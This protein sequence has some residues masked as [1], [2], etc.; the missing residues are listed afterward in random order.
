MKKLSTILLSLLLLICSSISYAQELTLQRE[1]KNAISK[2]TRTLSGDPGKNYWIN[3][4]DYSLDINVVF[5]GDTTWIVGSG[6]IVY[7]NN[8]P[9]DLN[10][11][12]L[13]SYPDI[14]APA[15]IRN[16]YFGGAEELDLVSYSDIYVNGDTIPPQVMYQVRTSTNIVLRLSEPIAAGDQAV[17]DIKWRYRMHPQINIRQGV[18][19]SKSL[20]IAYF[21]PQVAVYDDIYGW[22]LVDYM[23]SV[24]FYNDFNNYDVRI[25]LP[26][27]YIVWGGGTLQNPEKV[28]PKNILEGYQKALK[29]DNIVSIIN[30]DDLPLEKEIEG[31]KTWHFKSEKSPDFTFAASFTHKWDASSLEVEPGR[32]VLIS[33]VYPTN[34]AH[35]GSA[36]RWS[37]ESIEYLSFTCPGVAYPWPFMTVFNSAEGSGGME[38]PMMVNNGEQTTE[39]G[40]RDVIFHEIAHSYV[41]FLTGANERRWSWLDEG[42]ATY[43][44]LKWTYEIDHSGESDFLRIYRNISGTAS[45]IPLMVPSYQIMDPTASTNYSYGRSSQAFMV[46]ESQLGTEKM[47][48]LWKTFTTTWREKHPSPWDYFALVNRIAG[49]DMNWLLHPWYYEFKSADL[50]LAAVDTRRGE[51]TVK[52]I[53][54]LPL[55]VY[56]TLTYRDGSVKEIFRKPEI[57][58]TSDRVVIKID[59]AKE[60]DTAFIGNYKIFETD[61]SNNSWESNPVK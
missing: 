61:G 45:D 11:I 56:L 17:I 2:G 36:A 47:N 13:R 27:E 29:S 24:E 44:G 38:S 1:M 60:L 26:S 4:S 42:W 5:E 52:N 25:T 40:A 55:P 18:Y 10:M 49:K 48:L 33:A 46:T 37:R 6:H 34:S 41:P 51:L 58:K 21:Y 23:G 15:S 50:A 43:Q 57:W 12:V 31:L 22:D 8:S 9:R 39:L 20:F 59:R 14:Y 35:Y 54:G 28:Y 7:H 53:G 30:E 19:E 16:F 32:R 3:S